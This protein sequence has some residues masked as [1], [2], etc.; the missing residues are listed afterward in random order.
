MPVIVIVN[1]VNSSSVQIVDMV[2]IV[3]QECPT[4]EVI[5]SVKK[6]LYCLLTDS[7]GAGLAHS[8]LIMTVLVL[9]VSKSGVQ[10]EVLQHQTLNANLEI[11]I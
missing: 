10:K 1:S 11:I 5:M 3:N 7:T 2:S 8:I 9:E 6:D 4:L